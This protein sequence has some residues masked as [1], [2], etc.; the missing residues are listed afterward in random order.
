MH[1]Q[2]TLE[3]ALRGI[4][5]QLPCQFGNRTRRIS[6]EYPRGNRAEQKQ[7]YPNSQAYRCWP[8]SYLQPTVTRLVRLLGT[9]SDRISHQEL[10]LSNEEPG[11]GGAALQGPLRANI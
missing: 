4:A 6:Y 1:C 9:L 3:G 10:A 5:F 2:A 7:Y 8:F 11:L